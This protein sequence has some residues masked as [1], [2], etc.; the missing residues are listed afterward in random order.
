MALL[1]FDAHCDRGEQVRSTTAPCSSAVN[2]GLL[3][4]EHSIQFARAPQRYRRWYRGADRRGSTATGS[5]RRWRRSASGW[6]T[7]R[8]TWSFDIDASTRPL[9]RHRTPVAAACQPQAL[10]LIRGWAASIW[11]HGSG[12]G[13]SALRSR[14]DHR[15]GCGDGRL[16]LAVRDGAASSA[17]PVV[18][19]T[20]Q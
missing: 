13:F 18:S 1:Q 6:A 3:D 14:G 9:P 20:V 7:G 8:F 2:E 5:T 4:V 11:C 16:R 17:G 10:E 12:R 19:T 15:A